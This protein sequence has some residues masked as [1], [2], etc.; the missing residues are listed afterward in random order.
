MVRASGFF[1]GV[2]QNREAVEGTLVVD[3]LSEGDNGAGQPSGISDDRA[4]RVPEDAADDFGLK[5]MLGGLI[6][7]STCCPTRCPQHDFEKRNSG[8]DDIRCSGGGFV[9]P[10]P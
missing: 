7:F 3:G 9:L 10:A 6:P 8:R 5:L 1:Q 4:E 2:G